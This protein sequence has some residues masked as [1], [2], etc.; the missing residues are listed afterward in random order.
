[1]FSL[2]L[3][4]KRICV[5]MG[6]TS[7]LLLSGSVQVLAA[8]L[9]QDDKVGSVNNDKLGE[10]LASVAGQFSST[11]QLID[12][13]KGKIATDE[14][15]KSVTGRITDNSGVALAGVNVLEKNTTNGV[16]ADAEGKFTISVASSNSVL[17]FSFIGYETHEVA[18]GTQSTLNVSLT[19]ALTGL[20]EIIVVGYEFHKK[21]YFRIG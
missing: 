10:M 5:V 3:H 7:V 6:L 19:L 9:Q 14:Q 1:M 18:V 17:V 4:F 8:S 13:S 21:S 16:I 20:D 2:L 11:N 15:Q 12:V